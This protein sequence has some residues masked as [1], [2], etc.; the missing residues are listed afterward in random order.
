MRD[1]ATR[2]NAVA[3][4]ELSEVSKRIKELRGKTDLRQYEVAAELNVPPRTYQSW[5]N[6]EVET[7][8]ENYRK[9]GE[10]LGASANWI[11]F[12]QE[13]EPAG[14]DEPAVTSPDAI[15]AALGRIESRLRKLELGQAKLL[16][17]TA[18]AERRSDSPRKPEQRRSPKARAAG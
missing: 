9:I 2:N 13:E 17:R 10:L 15:L 8:R 16:A 18:Q 4:A 3:L 12:G 1:Y 7:D 11:L 14:E 5:E 6:G